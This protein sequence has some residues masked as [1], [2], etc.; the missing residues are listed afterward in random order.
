ML[1]DYD[2]IVI[3]YLHLFFLKIKRF[4]KKKSMEENKEMINEL[5]RYDFAIALSTFF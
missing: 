4:Q 5:G 3:L 1:R 2:S